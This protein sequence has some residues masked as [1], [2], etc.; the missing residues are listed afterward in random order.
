MTVCEGCSRAVI[1]VSSCATC[2]AD[3]CVAC[4]DKERGDCK[5][6]PTGE[7]DD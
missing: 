1:A 4:K 3:V 5:A 6:C 2:G 7:D